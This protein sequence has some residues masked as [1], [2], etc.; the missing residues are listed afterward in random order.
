AS[1]ADVQRF[2]AEAEAAANLDHP[3]IL[4]IYEV[5]EHEGQQ[6]FSMKLIDGGS[7]AD[8][9]NAKS[10]NEWQRVEILVKVARAVHF[11][12]QHGIL[13]RDL[14]PA[15]ILLDHAGTPYVTDFGLAKKV[16]G[17]CALT[18][19]GAIV[20]TPSYLAP[21]QARAEKSLTTAVD[22]YSLGAIL[23]ELLTG[24]PPFR[25][26]S[27]L[28][29]ILLVLDRE[30]A[31]PSSVSPGVP[32]DLETIALKCLDKAPGRRYESAGAL[33]DDLERFL[34]GEPIH[35]RSVPAWERAVKWA[36]RR[37]AIAALRGC[38]TLMAVLM[39][40]LTVAY[41][42][43][44]MRK[45]DR[46]SQVER[47][48]EER[49]AGARHEQRLIRYVGDLDKAHRELRDGWPMR[50]SDLL[51]R[52]QDFPALGWEWHYLKRRCHGEVLSFQCRYCV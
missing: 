5:G 45:R 49:L 37:P 42:I 31:R 2:R 18:Q 48:A 25:A 50:A 33:A 10:L 3:N 13:H 4:P 32:R 16:E 30:P 29:T 34:R 40:C 17:D 51:D 19:S 36:R 39:L 23:Y 27:H 22:V 44:L 41:Q 15:N 6:Y 43:D 35:A 26:D 21:E 14:K 24:R 47:E 28:E 46:I 8:A 38:V 7:L 1:A 20:G 12:H 9:I 52:Q 11:A